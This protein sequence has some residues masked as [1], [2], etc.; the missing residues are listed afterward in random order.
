MWCSKLKR[1]H[2]LHHHSRNKTKN[3]FLVSN[4]QLVIKSVFNLKAK[5]SLKTNCE[6]WGSPAT[7][8]RCHFP[9]TAWL[10]FTQIQN[11]YLSSMESNARK[12]YSVEWRRTNFTLSNTRKLQPH[13]LGKGRKEEEKN[14]FFLDIVRKRGGGVQPESKSFELV[15]FSPMLTLF[16]TLNGGRGGSDHVPIVLRHFL[17]IY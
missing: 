6:V 16:W 10:P 1:H 11:A 9:F 3:N 5:Y 14:V 17:P 4:Q 2:A 13:I 8:E 7:W 12:K 15:L